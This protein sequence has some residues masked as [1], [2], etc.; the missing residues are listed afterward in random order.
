MKREKFTGVNSIKFNR[1]FDGEFTGWFKT[2]DKFYERLW[3]K[4]VRT[5]YVTMRD[6][7]MDCPDR[8]RAQWWGD[9]V[10]KS[11]EAF[12]A[13]SPSAATITKKGILELI[14]W[15]REDG[16]IY[17][18]I[19]EGNWNKE[20]PGQMLASIGYYGFWNYYLNTGDKETLAQDK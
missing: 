3:G 16:T 2:N 19:P 4:A 10:N 14:N 9:M 18:P 15:Q 8:E 5:L 1:Q 17:S 13:L 20:L 11:G 7:Y 6:T 12:Y